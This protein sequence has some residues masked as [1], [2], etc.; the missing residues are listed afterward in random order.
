M[1][2]I[3]P[4]LV[5]FVLTFTLRASVSFTFLPPMPTA[6]ECVLTIE[7]EYY[8]YYEEEEYSDAFGTSFYFDGPEYELDVFTVT[9]SPYQ[10]YIIQ[11]VEDN[12]EY[13]SS[14]YYICREETT[15][16]K[17]ID[18]DYVYDRDDPGSNPDPDP[19]DSGNT[20]GENPGDG[21]NPG[22]GGG[23]DGA[24]GGGQQPP[25]FQSAWSDCFNVWCVN[26]NQY[27]VNMDGV[28]YD[29]LYALD[30]LYVRLV[31]SNGN[32]IGRGYYT[33]DGTGWAGW[34]YTGVWKVDEYVFSYSDDQSGYREFS[35]YFLPDW[36]REERAA[37]SKVQVFA[38][39]NG[40]QCLVAEE[41]LPYGAYPW[42]NNWDF[43][44]TDQHPWYGG[45]DDEYDPGLSNSTAPLGS[46]YSDALHG[47]WWQ[48]FGVSSYA[49]GGQFG[50]I[51]FWTNDKIY[52]L[53]G[54]CLVLTDTQGNQIGSARHVYDS[55]SYYDSNQR[56]FIYA[57]WEEGWRENSIIY[58]YNWW[59][60]NPSE[61]R[62]LKIYFIYKGRYYFITADE[63]CF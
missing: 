62:I 45:A 35:A 13:N 48:F 31:D 26:I 59:P 61:T 9:L 30:G 60:S 55:P 38:I 52:Q 27:G 28:T 44:T 58:Y 50:F 3:I 6:V 21:G 34:D 20:G 46:S 53:D 1:K 42:H 25:F 33:M 5:L 37:A 14:K 18:I 16:Y 36:T 11:D 40:A 49:G 54:A 29:R 4:I 15:T 51:D 19:D 2:K 17:L 57:S 10:T 39:W 56:T 41:S 23:N 24:G 8:Y 7:K 22:G 47:S 12:Y 43:L 63:V 32:K